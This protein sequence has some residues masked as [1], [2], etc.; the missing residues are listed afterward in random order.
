[1]SEA[2][3]PPRGREAGRRL[4]PATFIT[5]LPSGPSMSTISALQPNTNATLE[6]TVAAISPVRHVVT[7]R[8]PSD[9]ADATLQDDTGSVTFTLWGD[10]VAKF[11]V[12]QKVKIADGWVKEYRGKLQLSLGRSG[13]VVVLAA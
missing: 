7:S 8:G 13:S 4:R 9:V 10:Q 5:A 6:A 1:M 11:Q 3:P 2:R 12:G